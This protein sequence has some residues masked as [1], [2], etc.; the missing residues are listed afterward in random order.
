MSQ[1]ITKKQV[2]WP[3]LNTVIMVENV[4][5]NADESIIKVS[6]LKRR[7]PRKVNHNPS[8]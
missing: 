5:K 8:P 1:Q 7:L 6:E 4:I 2:H 3:N